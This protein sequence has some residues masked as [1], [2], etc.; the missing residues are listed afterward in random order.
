MSEFV[1]LYRRPVLPPGSPQEMQERMKRWRAWFDSL[2]K[3]GHL[4]NLGQPLHQSEGVVV[5]DAKGRFTDGPYAETKDVIMG[6]SL[7]KANDL[8][9]ARALVADWP[10][11]EDGG[12]IE[13]RPVMKM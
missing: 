4:A 9:Q 8:E 13:I 3:R 11:Y 5:R 1:Y 12:V 2:E 10:G 6:Y 7:I